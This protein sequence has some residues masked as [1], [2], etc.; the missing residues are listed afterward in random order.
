MAN[1]TIAEII[2]EKRALADRLEHEMAVAKECKE[3]TAHRTAQAIIDSTRREADRL[4]AAHRREHGNAAKLREA[5]TK[6]KEWMEH[7]IATCGFEFSATFPT[8]LED[9]VLP[10]LAEPPRNCD[11]G[12]PMEQGKRLSAYCRAHKHP[13]SECLPCPLFGQTGGYCELAWAQLAYE[14]GGD[15]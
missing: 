10:A 12:T 11:V 7:R 2:A 13:E 6:V 4:E 15:R 1:E 5:L 9:V 3:P 14:K 8:M